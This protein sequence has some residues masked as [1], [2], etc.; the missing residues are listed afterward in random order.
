MTKKAKKISAYIS[1]VL[2]P[3]GA[4]TLGLARKTSHAKQVSTVD[5]TQE[6]DAAFE[7]GFY[8]GGLD[9]QAARKVRPSIGRWNDP[10]DRASFLA[11]YERGYEQGRAGEIARHRH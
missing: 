7:D 10:K 5:A 4:A 3:F 9:A 1:L 11:G 6:T 8:L 2:I